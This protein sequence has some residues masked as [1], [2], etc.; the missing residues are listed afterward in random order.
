MLSI[1][2]I[3]VSIAAIM[4]LA[5]KKVPLYVYAPVCALIAAIAS[6][7]N[8]YYAMVD[9]FVPGIAEYV[10]KNFML[11]L[12]S[13]IFAFFMDESGAARYI[14]L[15]LSS[16]AKRSKHSKFAGLMLMALVQIVL[17]VGGINLFVVIF[18]MVSLNRTMYEELDI[19]WNLFLANMWA[20]GTV[21][22]WALPGMP[23]IQNLIPTEYLGTDAM[24]G[25]GLGIFMGIEI[26][27]LC[28]LYVWYCLR[29]A[30]KNKEHFLPQGEAVKNA[31]IN[32]NKEIPKNINMWM[33]LIPSAVVLITMNGFKLAPA[34]SLL[35]GSLIAYILFRKNIKNVAF[36]LRDG[37][38]NGLSVLLP[39]AFMAGYGTVIASTSGFAVIIEALKNI[40]G[41]EVVQ[42]YIATNVAACI[43]GSV[44]GGLGIV[45]T[46]LGDH[47][48]AMDLSPG[49]IHRIAVAGA[50]GLDTMPHAAS[51]HSLMRVSCIEFN[52]QSYKHLFMCNLVLTI[53]VGITGVIAVCLGIFV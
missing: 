14:A 6:G 18:L 24:A 27:V 28:I 22:V 25:A 13:A 46:T 52:W 31:E 43:C 45:M 33:A 12:S 4:A 50:S 53:I 40:Q 36:T 32:V 1:I 7:L 37:M 44:S 38:E 26:T 20:S 2:G 10:S 8:P 23:S 3:V 39:V 49:I 21:T 17:S 48:L 11:F 16:L 19:P 41:P 42:V 47:F 29:K 9:S 15:R 35:L 30:E 5:F 34:V 51:I